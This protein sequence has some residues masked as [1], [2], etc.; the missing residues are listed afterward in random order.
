MKAKI[1]ILG[2]LIGLT[3]VCLPLYV[4]RCSS[5]YFC[6][7]PVPFTLLEVLILLTFGFWLFVAKSQL[8]ETLLGIY[9]SIPKVVLFFVAVFLIS[10]LVAV[11]VA[12][13]KRA[14]LGIYKAY[15]VEGFLLFVVVYDYLRTTKNYKLIIWSLA[16]SSLWVAILAVFNQLL[17]FNPG[18][19][20]EFAERG[21]SSALF[22]TSNA[23]GL[24]LGPTQ[25][26]LFGYFLWLKT[27]NNSLLIEK[28]ITLIVS[29]II[30]CGLLASGS[31]G[32]FLGIIAASI[33]FFI[34]FLYSKFSLKAKKLIIF[35]FKG[36]LALLFL[37]I[38]MVLFNISY[39]V[40]NPPEIGSFQSGLNQRLCLWEGTVEIIKD[41]P[42]FGS[43]L[44][45]FQRVHDQYRT[46]S[47]EQ[48]LYPHNLFLNFWTE[49]SIF[50]LIS[51][52]ALALY[53]FFILLNGENLFKIG[54]AAVFVTFFVH[55]LVDV[56]FFKNDLSAQF[57][58]ILALAAYFGEN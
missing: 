13:D 32:A 18:N 34:Y 27:N 16:I 58:T 2:F 55:G 47:L 30:L 50:G 44:N 45:G 40:K 48:S 22:S 8:A 57:W 46:C 7:S 42:V 6:N 1:K 35:G 56:P 31:R 24:L 39:F 3:L 53:S 23:V 51:F 43:G 26:L 5:F 38:F 11:F 20:A 29:L 10:G 17:L 33:F 9:G 37:I 21:R 15:F 54:I 41:K 52:V 12:G 4:I 25:V 19:P 36:F 49:L 14:A 28:K